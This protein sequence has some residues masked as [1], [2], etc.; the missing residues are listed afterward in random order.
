MLP[1]G[2]RTIFMIDEQGNGRGLTLFI[3]LQRL[4]VTLQASDP[5]PPLLCLSCRTNFATSK[6][7]SNWSTPRLVRIMEPQ[8]VSE[9]LRVGYRRV[10]VPVPVPPSRNL[11]SSVGQSRNL[12][13]VCPSLTADRISLTRDIVPSPWRSS[14]CVGAKNLSFTLGSNILKLPKSQGSHL[15]LSVWQDA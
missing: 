14:R 11:A 13:R 6:C 10:I 1:G 9:R 8:L 7:R 12:L 2:N 4:G 5:L 15:Q 3:F